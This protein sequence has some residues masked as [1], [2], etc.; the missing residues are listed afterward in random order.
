[1]RQ[2]RRVSVHIC[3]CMS[4]MRDVPSRNLRRPSFVSG[5]K[6]NRRASD[7]YVRECYSR[8]VLMTIPLCLVQ[9]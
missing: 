7:D 4:F 1:M 3:A 9:I 8:Y 6:K 5:D 2:T